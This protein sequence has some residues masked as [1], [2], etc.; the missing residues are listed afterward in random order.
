[1]VLLGPLGGRLAS[2][3]VSYLS[4]RQKIPNSISI[5]RR[6]FFVLPPDQLRL[7]SF[8]AAS[9]ALHASV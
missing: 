8:P 7:A 2:A 5:D 6:L 9:N 4:E 1:M 3:I